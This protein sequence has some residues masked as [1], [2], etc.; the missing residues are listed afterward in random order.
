MQ[1]HSRT[2]LLALPLLLFVAGCGD[3][4]EATDDVVADIAP[5]DDPADDGDTAGSDIGTD[6]DAAGDAVAMD[7]GEQPAAD[8]TGEVAV[9]ELTPGTCLLMPGIGEVD[10]IEVTSCDMPHDGEVFGVLYLDDPLETPYPGPEPMGMI[11]NDACIDGPF[12]DYIGRE[13]ATSEIYVQSIA[14]I[15]GSWAMG[16]RQVICI[17]VLDSG[18]LTE[19]IAG[20]GR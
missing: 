16:D 20:S 12:E 11:G 19:S 10:T 6:A 15:A 18:Q 3:G 14:P 17:G 4:G 7:D 1:F 2:A 8:A 9:R 5:V 13:Y